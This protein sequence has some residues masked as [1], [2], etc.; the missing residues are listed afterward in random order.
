MLSQ[1]A[2][3]GMSSPESP[4]RGMTILRTILRIAQIT[5]KIAETRTISD[6]RLELIISYLDIMAIIESMPIGIF[7][8]AMV[9]TTIQF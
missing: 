6:Q 2:G 8:Q 1:H 7:I 9:S 3:H 4:R 5:H